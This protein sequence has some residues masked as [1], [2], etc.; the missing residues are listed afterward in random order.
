MSDKIPLFKLIIDELNLSVDHRGKALSHVADLHSVI[1]STIKGDEKFI[2]GLTRILPPDN[3]PPDAL[4]EG[5]PEIVK[6]FGQRRPAND[7]GGES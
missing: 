3:N 4:D 7:N 2:A 1:L 6:Q 5:I